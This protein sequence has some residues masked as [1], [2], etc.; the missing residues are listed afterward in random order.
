MNI[1]KYYSKE[2]E[3]KY[4]VLGIKIDF[5]TFWSLDKG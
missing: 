2:D 3:L 1:Y 5:V 4:G